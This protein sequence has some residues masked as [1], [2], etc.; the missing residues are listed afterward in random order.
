MDPIENY[1]KR[2]D[3]QYKDYE[4]LPC[5]LYSTQFEGEHH[6]KYKIGRFKGIDT[7]RTNAGTLLL[8]L[9]KTHPDS[10]DIEKTHFWFMETDPYPK[11]N[12]SL[13]TFSAVV[14]G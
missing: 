1:P 10:F 9:Y 13:S 5:V 14:F 3:Q 11:Y 8:S 6:K 12:N 2:F 7:E 4:F